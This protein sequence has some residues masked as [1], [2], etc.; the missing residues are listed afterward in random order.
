MAQTRIIKQEG[1]DRMKIVLYSAE[2]EYALKKKYFKALNNAHIHYHK[3]NIVFEGVEEN[4]VTFIEVNNI[5][6][7]FILSKEI[8][9]E[10]VIG[11]LFDI[12]EITI[13]DDYME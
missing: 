10:L 9:Y 8:G 12:P 7:L 13:Y 3:E 11:R 6:D 1:F 2:N 5:E 4:N